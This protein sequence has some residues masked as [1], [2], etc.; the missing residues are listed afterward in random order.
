[1]I[2][3]HR[4]SSFLVTHDEFLLLLARLLDAGQSD[5][6]IGGLL[7]NVIDQLIL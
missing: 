5:R 2:G 6:L 4:S 1:M 7:I 3:S